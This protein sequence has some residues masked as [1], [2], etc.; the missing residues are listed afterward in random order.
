MQAVKNVSQN[1][2]PHEKITFLISESEF[3][4]AVN[5]S[6]RLGL[7]SNKTSFFSMTMVCYPYLLERAMLDKA[8]SRNSPLSI[9]PPGNHHSP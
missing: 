8:S 5:D 2:L 4:K 6:I 3:R 7:E 9:L 1:Y